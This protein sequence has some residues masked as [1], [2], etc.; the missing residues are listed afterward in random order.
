MK[1]LTNPAV[2]SVALAGLL[3]SGVALADRDD[4]RLLAET[5]IN[6]TEAIAIA[7][8][9]QNG[10]AYEAELDSDSFSPVYEVKVVSADNRVFE[11]DVDGV[12]GEVRSVKEK[13]D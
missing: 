5:K 6:L 4:I 11:L 1:K 8:K 13:R 9:H 7:E 3:F 12:S 10:R 2:L